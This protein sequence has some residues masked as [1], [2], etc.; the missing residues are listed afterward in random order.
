MHPFQRFL[1]AAALLFT[2]ALAGCGGDDSPR[3]ELS[4]EPTTTAR[5]STADIDA[6]VAA[7]PGLVD[8]VGG[9]ARCAVTLQ[10]LVYQTVAPNGA[11]ARASLG[12]LVPQ[13][14]A[15]PYPTVVY[16]HGTQLLKS[17]A[18]SDPANLETFL[19]NAYFASQGY[20]VVMPDYLGYGDS[21][22]DFHPYLDV[23]SMADVAIDALRAARRHL[24]TQGVA[25]S[26]KLFLTG[27][28]QGGHSAMATQRVME[29]DHA[30]EFAITATAPMAGF[31]ALT[32]TFVDA[33]D[34]PTDLGTVL[35]AFGLTGLQAVY[36]DVYSA[37]G[38]AFQAPWAAGVEG[39]LP[40]TLELT[41]LFTQGK[42][43][44]Q[45]LT[46]PGGLLTDAFAATL[47]NDANSGVRRRLAQ[48]DLIDWTPKAPMTM[49]HGGRDTVVPVKNMTL[50]AAA[51]TQRGAPVTA[52]DLEDIAA[53]K[54]AIDAQIAAAG[55]LL[56]YHAQIA[57][58]LCFS[59]T[60]NQ[61]FDPLR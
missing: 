17:F 1:G 6:S 28:S 5:L 55:T 42:L 56:V 11:P 38:A 40:G 34:A 31:Y 14:C 25:S 32:A 9:P 53:F 20:V 19:A 57:P 35:F 49:C 41:A 37:A 13:D 22:L 61:V 54:P 52:I 36:G 44:A 48:N 51:F 7:L 24:A 23:Q 27:Y 2:L 59:V 4:G 47:K 33:L 60:K 58:P 3:G 50:A 15:G 43:P 29:R 46:G 21:S 16:H 39:L 45:A 10:K 8:L 26:G 30:Q 18:M 12:L